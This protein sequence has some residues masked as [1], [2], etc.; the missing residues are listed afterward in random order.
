LYI[1]SAVISIDRSVNA[2]KRFGT[3][4]DYNIYTNKG[5]RTSV[6]KANFASYT[7]HAK[8]CGMLIDRVIVMQ[9]TTR[10][11]SQEECDTF[12]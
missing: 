11:H 2:I 1:G 4:Q 5:L 3:I 12:S 8:T 6:G 7:V 10:H 9:R